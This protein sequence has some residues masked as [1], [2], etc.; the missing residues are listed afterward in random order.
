MAL[1]VAIFNGD[2]SVRN[3]FDDRVFHYVDNC[4]G[5]A[6][7]SK[8]RCWWDHVLLHSCSNDCVY[9][10]DENVFVGV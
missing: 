4:F 2:F 7:F 8:V 6:L 10:L 5:S 1:R 9:Y 3:V